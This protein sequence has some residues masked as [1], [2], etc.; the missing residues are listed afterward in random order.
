MYR[1]CQ[2]TGF[3][4]AV[5]GHLYS[6]KIPVTFPNPQV[7]QKSHLEDSRNQKGIN[8]KSSPTRFS[9]N[10]GGLYRYQPKGNTNIKCL[11]KVLGHHES[12]MQL[13]CTWHRFY[14]SLSEGCYTILPQDIPSFYGFV[15]V[16]ENAVSD[17]TPETPISVQ[18]G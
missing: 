1:L 16:L 2:D 18:L 7:S 4:Q 10:P 17:A 6:C 13:Q 14:K 8:R 12:P 11:N 9:A 15:M 5:S 3:V